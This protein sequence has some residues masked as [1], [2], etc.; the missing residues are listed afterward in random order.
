MNNYIYI[1]PNK[2]KIKLI[3]L[4]NKFNRTTFFENCIFKQTYDDLIIKLLLCLSNKKTLYIGKNFLNKSKKYR[5][6]FK[7]PLT[8]PKLSKFIN[9]F[10]SSSKIIMNSSGTTGKK[11]KIICSWGQITRNISHKKKYSNNIWALAYNMD[12]YAGLQVLLQAFLNFN[13]LVD[14]SDTKTEN[15]FLILKKYKITNISATPT[16]YRKLI[17]Q[18]EKK[19][20]MLNRI[21]VGGE[22]SNKSLFVNLKKLF[23][24][25]KILN[26]YAS[27]EA[28]TILASKNEK[29]IIPSKSKSLIKI[30]NG[31]LLIHKSILAK[32]IN[33]C[34]NK[35]WYDSNDR[36]KLNDDGKFE[37]I[38]RESSFINTGGYKVNPEEIENIMN[39]HPVIY[40]ARIF[41]RKNSFLGN[42]LL[43]E[44][45]LRKK[46]FIK[47]DIKKNILRYLKKKLLKWKIPVDIYIVPYIDRTISGKIKR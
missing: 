26:I 35:N 33:T 34:V 22:I 45:V 32:N 5:N 17:M 15:I 46:K 43:A 29:F 11:K 27:T 37:F 1:N 4:I 36:V 23:P 41:S 7:L 31:K 3:E 44:V 6:N 10:S 25:A 20:N 8:K 12:H 30:K 2:K 9:S 40:D 19:N 39:N 24:T 38:G 13:I 21:S 18:S 28:G 14:I 47:K 42:V 16:F